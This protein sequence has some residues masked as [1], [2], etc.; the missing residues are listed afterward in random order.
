MSPDGFSSHTHKNNYRII[1]K[2]GRFHFFQFVA[3][4]KTT[5][6]SNLQNISLAIRMQI[7]VLKNDKKNAP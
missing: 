5:V 6:Y 3:T 7:S 1:I 2:F 4:W